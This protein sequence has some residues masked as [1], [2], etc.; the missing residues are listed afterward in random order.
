MKKYICDICCKE[1]TERELIQIRMN[2][3]NFKSDRVIAG[4]WI[5]S[6]HELDVCSKCYPVMQDVFKK[7]TITATRRKLKKSCNSAVNTKQD[8]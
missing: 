5:D 2:G 8:M 6:L 3:L 7:A 1:V 4:K